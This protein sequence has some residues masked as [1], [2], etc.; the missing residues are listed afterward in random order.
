MNFDPM[1]DLPGFVRKKI[2]TAQG[3]K[4][5]VLKKCLEKLAQK[6]K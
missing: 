4:I 6:K 5:E 3:E 2:H 1:A